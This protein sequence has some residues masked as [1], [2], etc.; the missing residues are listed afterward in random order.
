MST[1]ELILY[2]VIAVIVVI[3]IVYYLIKAIKNHWHS[4]GDVYFRFH[5]SGK[6]IVYTYYQKAYRRYN[7]NWITNEEW[8][9]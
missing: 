6:N 9:D 8:W 2:T 4:Y 5:K 3:L 1:P 7:Y